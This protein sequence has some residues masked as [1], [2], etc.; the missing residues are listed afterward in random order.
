VASLLCVAPAHQ[1][2]R[3]ADG[4]GGG[5][6]GEVGRSARRGLARAKRR[7]GGVGCS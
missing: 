3:A 6:K 1:E 5:V 2:T 7:G 4:L